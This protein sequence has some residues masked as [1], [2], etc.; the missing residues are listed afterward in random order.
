[1]AD[2]GNILHQ[3]ALGNIRKFDVTDLD[4]SFVSAVSSH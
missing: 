3:A 1:M 4:R 2:I